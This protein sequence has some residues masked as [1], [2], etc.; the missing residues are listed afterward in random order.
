[1]NDTAAKLMALGDWARQG[2]IKYTYM[3]IGAMEKRRG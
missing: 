3:V 1:M 2:N